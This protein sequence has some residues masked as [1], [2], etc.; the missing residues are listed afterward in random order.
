M[1]TF[2]GKNNE[3]L[4][5]FLENTDVVVNPTLVGD[6]PEMTGIQV[7]GQKYKAPQG[8]GSSDL[9]GLYPNTKLQQLDDAL[10]L[11]DF[12]THSD[13][14]TYIKLSDLMSLLEEK[15]DLNTIPLDTE[16]IEVNNLHIRLLTS[17]VNFSDSANINSSTAEIYLEYRE[18]SATHYLTLKVTEPLSGMEIFY[19]RTEVSFEPSGH[20]F[21]DLLEYYITNIRDIE[22]TL[23]R[24]DSSLQIKFT[25]ELEPAIYQPFFTCLAF[26]KNI[27]DKDEGTKEVFLAHLDMDSF[28]SKIHKEE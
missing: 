10:V 16:Y 25:R 15:V 19:E 3:V 12:D 1:K 4:G 18:D 28:I 2:K 13:E 6:E 23:S 27:Y 24:Y 22:I 5:T 21:K 26:N 17:F 7:G 11:G 8:G 14:Y 9:G 20:T